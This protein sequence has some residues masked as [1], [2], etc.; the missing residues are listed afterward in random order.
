MSQMRASARHDSA[1]GESGRIALTS[2][3]TI[4][5]FHRD[6][7]SLSTLSRKDVRVSSRV[8]FTVSG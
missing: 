2:R 3:S 8:I 7:A 6:G 5:R 1:S 4:A